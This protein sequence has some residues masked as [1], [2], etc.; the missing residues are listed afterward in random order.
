M[1]L[2]DAIF[3][4]IYEG[5]LC[6]HRVETNI[7]L[8]PRDNQKLLDLDYWD[9]RMNEHRPEQY[10]EAQRKYIAARHE[11][12][13]RELPKRYGIDDSRLWQLYGDC[14]EYIEIEGFKHPSWAA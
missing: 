7:R 14:V 1:T 2:D 8:S 9:W 13:Y 4:L 6:W 11:A 5:A 10:T 12:F 3:D